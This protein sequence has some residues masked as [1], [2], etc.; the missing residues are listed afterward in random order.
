MGFA[1]DDEAHWMTPCTKQRR[2]KVMQDTWGADLRRGLLNTI[3]TT[4]AAAA[5][6]AATAATP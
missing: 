6:A 1:S 4:A 3:T 5:A 2:V